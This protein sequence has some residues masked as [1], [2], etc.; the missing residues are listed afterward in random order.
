MRLFLPEHPDWNSEDTLNCQRFFFSPTWAK[1][2]ERIRNA[3][4]DSSGNT[5]EQRMHT[6]LQREQIE[7]T[8]DALT[9]LTKTEQARK[10]DGFKQLDPSLGTGIAR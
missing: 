6:L 4:P 8:V 5:D 2:L 10:P 9:Q 7:H 3:K 1:A